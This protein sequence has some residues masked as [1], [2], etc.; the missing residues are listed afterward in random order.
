MD[1]STISPLVP[2]LPQLLF[3]CIKIKKSWGKPRNEATILLNSTN[4]LPIGLSSGEGEGS[5]CLGDK[6]QSL[7]A[8]CGPSDWGRPQPNCE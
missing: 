4:P 2:R 1:P 5:L 7:D 8:R 6:A 3:N